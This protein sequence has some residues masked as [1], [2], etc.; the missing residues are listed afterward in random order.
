MDKQVVGKQAE[1]YELSLAPDYVSDWTFNDA[2]RELIQ[3]GIDQQTINPNNTFSIS[4]DD[5]TEELTLRNVQSK[6]K[7]DTLL[8]GCSSKSNNEETVGQFGE[9][10]KIAALVLT[11]LGKTFTIYNNDKNEI[12]TCRFKNST[13][14]L[15]KLLAFYIEKKVTEN[16]GLDIVIGNVSYDEC[17]DIANVWL[18]YCDYELEK[19]HTSYGDIL[20]D[21]EQSKRIYVNGL[22]VYT[23]ESMKYGFN[24]KPKY[25]KLERDRKTCSSWDIGEITS[26][27]IMEAA[28]SGDI[29]IEDVSEMMD[30]YSGETYHFQFNKYSANAKV[31][32]RKLLEE[33]D[34]KNPSLSVP[35]HT[36]AQINR[37]K[38]IG[39]NPVV[40]S[41]R[42][43]DLLS[44]EIEKRIQILVDTIPVD[45][46]TLKEKLT[47]WLTTYQTDL[48]EKAV[49]EMNEIINSLD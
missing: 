18:D 48:K 41:S 38:A 5:D 24:F 40:V 37:V 36:Q 16:T 34:R 28:I 2:I 25:I 31:L 20:M 22:Y 17:D 11:R 14:W 29:S 19:I 4:Y 39:G 21:E 35:V 46:L 15:H 7:R 27:M 30:G 3:N 49:D 13:K 1:C 42:I 10:Y 33:F 32:S 45:T 44:E 26:M 47:I 9:G 6:L 23:D 12:W 43:V 8:L